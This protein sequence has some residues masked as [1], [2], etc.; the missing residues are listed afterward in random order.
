MRYGLQSRQRSLR[1]NARAVR[2]RP[3]SALAAAAVS[4]MEKS[5]DKWKTE[6][7]RMTKSTNSGGTGH[8]LCG[9]VRYRYEGEPVTIGLCQCDRCQRQSGSAF[10]IG[11]I[12]PRDAVTIEGKLTTFETRLDGKNRLWRHFCPT[13]GSAVSITLDR[14]P[15]IRS[16]MGGTLDDKTKIN[17]RFSVWCSAGQPWIRMPDGIACFD[18]YPEGTFGG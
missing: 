15:E 11:I 3:T 8:C 4:S 12:F 5:S 18:D 2:S 13:C 14:Y 1:A 10:L 6:N 17:P 16:M 9:A 7:R